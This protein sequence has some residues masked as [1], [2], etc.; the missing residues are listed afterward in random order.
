MRMSSVTVTVPTSKDHKMGLVTMFT[1]ND[2]SL[3]I[4]ETC[5]D[6]TGW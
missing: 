5:D 4:L 2:M 3:T 6:G 1:T